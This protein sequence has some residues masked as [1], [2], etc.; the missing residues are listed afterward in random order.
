MKCMPTVYS[1]TH[2]VLRS[3]PSATVDAGERA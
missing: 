3:G 2:C 1:G